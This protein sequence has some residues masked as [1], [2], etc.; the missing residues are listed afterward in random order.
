M[1]HEKFFNEFMEEKVNLNKTR[2]ETLQKRVGCIKGFLENNL[3]G[4]QAIENQGSYG[5]KTIIKP[6]KEK[7]FD[8]DIMVYI[9]DL[10][11]EAKEYI[12]NIYKLFKDDGNY[13]DIVKR[14]TRCVTI[15][16]S[17][18]FHLDIV[19]CIEKKYICNKKENEFEITDGTAYKNWLIGKNEK[20]GGY[21]K[22]VIKLVKYMRDIKTN[23]SCKSILLTTLL[24]N[25]IKDS[26]SVSF[27][28]LP[29]ALKHI[30]NNLNDFLQNNE[31]MPT[32]KN[33]VLDD[34]DFN[35]HWDEDKY[36][37]FRDKIKLYTDKIN[38]AYNSNDHNESVKKWREI[39][40]DDFGTLDDNIPFISGAT[41][42]YFT[43][44]W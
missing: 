4:Y 37:N 14:K 44:L 22:K 38:E 3:E 18:D 40:G 5:S 9:E 21:L 36:S 35:R 31:H 17:G 11:W 42:P 25:Q 41:K 24:G 7:D 27:S 43:I 33:P 26:D 23:F 30:M 34:E 1:K 16:Y 8:A 13:K 12:E 10:D 6:P 39:F 15:D 2:L 28:D 20:S 29:T 19:P 32:I